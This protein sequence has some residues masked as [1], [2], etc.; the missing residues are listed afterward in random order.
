MSRVVR[1][2]RPR[3][4]RTPRATLM[5]VIEESCCDGAA[6]M[7]REPLHAAR[8]PQSA[9]MR[10]ADAIMRCRDAILTQSAGRVLCLRG[11]M[12]IL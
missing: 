8:M 7:M 5:R 9:L 2:G 1:S 4:A 6:C 3:C 11:F 10:T 12:L